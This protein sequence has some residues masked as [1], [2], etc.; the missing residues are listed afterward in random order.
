[1]N[2]LAKNEA[3][4]IEELKKELEKAKNRL[5]KLK[6]CKAMECSSCGGK[7]YTLRY[8]GLSCCDGPNES[9]YAHDTCTVC[10]GQGYL[11]AMLK[12]GILTRTYVE[13]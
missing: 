8:V 2:I 3:E 9:P 6:K 5:K 12:D 11:P 13:D 1:M 4:H 7:G 10:H